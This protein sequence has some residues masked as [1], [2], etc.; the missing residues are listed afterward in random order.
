V[1]AVVQP[2][3]GAAVAPQLMVA[4]VVHVAGPGVESVLSSPP[5]ALSSF[6][7]KLQHVHWQWLCS[8]S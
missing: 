5:A 7:S 1:V 2:A 4:E 6:V 3:D 8:V